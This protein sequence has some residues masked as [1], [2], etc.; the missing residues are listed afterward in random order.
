MIYLHMD[1]QGLSMWMMQSVSIPPSDEVKKELAK[2]M[3][4]QQILKIHA[5]NLKIQSENQTIMKNREG[6][7]SLDFPHWNGHKW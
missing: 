4:R 1:S 2:E 7:T 6:T 5:E 3:L